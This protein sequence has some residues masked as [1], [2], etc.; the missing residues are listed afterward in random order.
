[1][2]TS[3]P[4]R[5]GWTG[6]TLAGLVLLVGYGSAYLWLMAPVEV[7]SQIPGPHDTQR[8]TPEY[9]DYFGLKFETVFAPAHWLD[10]KVRP[11]FWGRRP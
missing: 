2:L 1:M 10:R 4:K 11:A 9:P 6:W 8:R 7:V 3:P 5:G